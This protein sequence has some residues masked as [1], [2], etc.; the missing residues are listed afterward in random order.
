MKMW[1][2]ILKLKIDNVPTD[3]SLI[4]FRSNIVTPGRLV[5]INKWEFASQIGTVTINSDTDGSP[6]L[7]GTLNLIHKNNGS[8]KFEC[9]A[10][11]GNIRT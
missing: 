9:L 3:Q 4:L 11:L 10:Y 6:A 7:L 8:H 2:S 5:S 1:V